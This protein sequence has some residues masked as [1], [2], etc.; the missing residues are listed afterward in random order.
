MSGFV[1]VAPTT[2][3]PDTESDALA[4]DGWF[5]DLSL[6][7]IRDSTRLD[8]TITDARLRDAARYAM[9]EVN[10][11][12]EAYK[13]EQVAA[14]VA[15]LAEVNA[16]EIAGENRL[17]MLYRRAVTCTLHADLLER[18]RDF[19]STEAGLRRATELDP[20]VG[21]QRRN[22]RWAVSDIQGK[23]H[24]VVDLI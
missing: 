7:A 12:L 11:L 9:S 20:A 16:A 17:L 10:R 18:Y 6:S 4:N 19:D 24:S 5:P 21:E 13:A 15:S 1:A 14:G 23:P 3:E 2:I 22:A 8:G